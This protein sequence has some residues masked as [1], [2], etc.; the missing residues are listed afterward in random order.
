MNTTV[1][2]PMTR[3]QKECATDCMMAIQWAIVKAER[4]GN[5]PIATPSL[6]YLQRMGALPPH[7]MRVVTWIILQ[8]G[9]EREVACTDYTLHHAI[10]PTDMKFVLKGLNLAAAHNFIELRKVR[11]HMKFEGAPI[12]LRFAILKGA[13]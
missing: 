5:R 6:K 1:L 2:P 11:N 3:Q 10:L 12:L 8:D 13:K 9:V 7:A 4:D